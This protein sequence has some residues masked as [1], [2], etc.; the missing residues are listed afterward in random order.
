MSATDDTD[1]NHKAANSPLHGWRQ[2]DCVLG[3]HWFAFRI[4]PTNP[5]TEAAHE[6]AREGADLAET[7][8]AGLVVATQTCD[9]LRSERAFV[10]VCPLVEVSVSI[11]SDI[12]RK[13]R[14]RYAVV[15]A[16]AANRLVA[17]LDRAMTVEKPVLESWI[18]VPGWESHAEGRAFAEALAR[19]RSRP[20][21]PDEFVELVRGFQDRIKDKHKLPHSDEGAAVRSIH[22]IRVQASPGW[23]APQISLTFWFITYSDEVSPG[24]EDFVDSWMDRIPRTVSFVEVD[25]Y[26]VSLSQMTAA[27]YVDSDRL[28]LDYLS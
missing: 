4:D 19:K 8:V 26:S 2:G 22:E 24:L 18:R 16:L 20:A 15:P 1:P 5:L 3:D 12:T 13:T 9:I 7:L 25:G 6:A 27:E 11:Y 14:P 23:Q 28:D 10:E 21:F 17:D